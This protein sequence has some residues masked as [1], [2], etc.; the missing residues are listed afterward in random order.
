MKF[1]RHDQKLTRAKSLFRDRK[2]SYYLMVCSATM[3]LGSSRSYFRA[4]ARWWACPF[5]NSLMEEVLG[6]AAPFSS[7]R[8]SHTGN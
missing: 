4:S 1:K 2:R 5:W 7:S 3:F 8:G 6:M